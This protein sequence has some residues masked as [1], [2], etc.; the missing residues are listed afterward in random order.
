MPQYVFHCNDDGS[1]LYKEVHR[2]PPYPAIAPDPLAWVMTEPELGELDQTTLAAIF[3]G[4]QVVG[5]AEKP[6]LWLHGAAE[7]GS[8]NPQGTRYVRRG[9]TLTFAAAIRVG[10]DPASAVVESDPGTGLPLTQEWGLELRGVSGAMWCPM[11]AVTN[12]QASGSVVV[13]E[14]LPDG[15]FCLPEELLARIGGYRLRL[16]DPSAWAFKVVS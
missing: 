2:T 10:A 3:E 11:V 9:E 12:G 15:D 14:R 5:V 6:C 13:P 4:G 8:T 16:A 7:G 1:V